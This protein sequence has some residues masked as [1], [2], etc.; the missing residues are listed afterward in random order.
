MRRVLFHDPADPTLPC[1][2]GKYYAMVV[3]AILV[4]AFAFVVGQFIA[5]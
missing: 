3:L 4:L 5:S 2:G 1:H